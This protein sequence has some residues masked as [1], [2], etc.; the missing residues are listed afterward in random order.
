[1]A[2]GYVAEVYSL[3][4]NDDSFRVYGIT[5]VTLSGTTLTFTTTGFA[6]PGST[7]VSM[8]S[9]T[10]IRLYKG[11]AWLADPG[12]GDASTL[13]PGSSAMDNATFAR[14]ASVGDQFTRTKGEGVSSI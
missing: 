11:S 8:L 6:G 2:I 5:A 4:N 12:P 10:E 14:A 1:M 13:T 3:F 9:A 7:V